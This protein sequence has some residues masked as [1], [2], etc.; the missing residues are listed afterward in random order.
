MK[1]Y[2]KFLF[3]NYSMVKMFSFGFFFV[4]VIGLL[5]FC[6][7][8]LWLFEDWFVVYGIVILDRLYNLLEIRITDIIY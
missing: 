6:V 8:F 4:I 5:L 1:V 7:W 2:V 3:E